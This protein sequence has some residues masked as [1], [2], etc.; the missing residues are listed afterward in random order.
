MRIFQP[1]AC[2]TLTKTEFLSQSVLNSN[3]NP[4]QIIVPLEEYE[5]TPV[6]KPIFIPTTESLNQP[7]IPLQ[8]RLDSGD[9][10]R[11]PTSRIS[12]IP[13]DAQRLEA[14]QNYHHPYFR[15]KDPPIPEDKKNDTDSD[16]ILHFDN[17]SHNDDE[18]KIGGP[19]IF[20]SFFLKEN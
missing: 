17:D 7:F 8:K 5:T 20:V 13:L 15:R 4:T 16:A 6:T 1:P 18:W 14:W 9:F 2:P 3:V 19:I 11:S 12:Y 10:R